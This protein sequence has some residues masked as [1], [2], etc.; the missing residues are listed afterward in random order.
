ML[1]KVQVTLGEI[2]VSFVSLGFYNGSVFDSSPS[3]LAQLGEMQVTLGEIGVSFL[4]LRF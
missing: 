4:S 1:G 2:G 3:L